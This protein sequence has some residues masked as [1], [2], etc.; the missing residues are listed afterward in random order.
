MTDRLS[1]PVITVF[2][3]R[4]LLFIIYI[5]TTYINNIL[6]YYI[7]GTTIPWNLST[8]VAK[9]CWSTQQGMNQTSGLD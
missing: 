6:L 8:P 2:L 7:R 5:T 1:K 9:L 4:R 3:N